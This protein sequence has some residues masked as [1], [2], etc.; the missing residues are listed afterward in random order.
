MLCMLLRDKKILP[1]FLSMYRRIGYFLANYTTACLC[2]YS[3]CIIGI[4]NV[5]VSFV[6]LIVTTS[7]VRE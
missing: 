1:V 7:S 4:G 6:T 3:G 5:M 2:Y